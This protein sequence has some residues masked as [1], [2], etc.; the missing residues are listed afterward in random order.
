MNMSVKIILI[1]NEAQYFFEQQNKE[2]FLIKM[3][4]MYRLWRKKY[5]YKYKFWLRKW[6]II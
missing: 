3:N 1:N 5:L 4:A 2:F 6:N